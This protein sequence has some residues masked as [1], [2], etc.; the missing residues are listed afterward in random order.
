MNS[1]KNQTI[2]IYSEISAEE[3]YE[4]TNEYVKPNTRLIYDNEF[5]GDWIIDIKK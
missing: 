2:N 3:W 1:N 4:A 5:G